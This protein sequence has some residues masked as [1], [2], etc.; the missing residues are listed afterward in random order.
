MSFGD[1]K[2]DGR[3]EY[4]SYLLNLNFDYFDINV[5]YG[6]LMMVGCDV[7]S[8]NYINIYIL[9]KATFIEKEM[10]EY[11]CMQKIKPTEN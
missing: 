4:N 11:N 7:Y 9:I 8:Q 3:W 10:K 6:L 1:D 5:I 2:G